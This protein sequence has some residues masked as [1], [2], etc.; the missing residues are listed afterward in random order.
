MFNVHHPHLT[1]EGYWETRSPQ[2]RMIVFSGA[3]LSKD[4]GLSVFR[5]NDGLWEN[6][7]I[8]EVC[9][10][11]TWRNHRELVN[12][13][14]DQR[15]EASRAAQPHDGH[16]WCVEMEREGAVLITQNVDDLLEKAGARH[17]I[18]IH[19]RVDERA[20][21][22]CSHVW[23]QKL[24][25]QIHC[26]ICDSEDTRVNVVF[27]HE[28]APMYAP[29]SRA[30]GGLRPQDVLVVVGTSGR[31]VNPLR[32]L[33]CPVNIW[34]VDPHPAPLLVGRPNTCVLPHAAQDL[35]PV[36]EARWQHHLKKQN[37]RG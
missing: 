23:S 30:I 22:A 29:A 6:H 16:R 1:P 34:V 3:G 8:E 5:G 14:Y 20:C 17:A 15:F 25:N 4:S 2:P 11:R 24:F 26:P 19:G 35:R 28:S 9:N 32:W 12:R 33:T 31:V 13:F 21:W 7:R 18:H 37:A 27:F 36:L 10:G